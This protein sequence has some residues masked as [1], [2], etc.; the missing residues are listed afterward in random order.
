MNLPAFAV[1]IKGTSVYDAKKGGFIDLSILDVLQ[2]FGRAGRYVDNGMV[3]LWNRA[4]YPQGRSTKIT[5]SVI[6]LR[7]MISYNIMFP[8]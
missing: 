2:I 8:P 1:I 6:S 3:G 7:R 5:V 4:H